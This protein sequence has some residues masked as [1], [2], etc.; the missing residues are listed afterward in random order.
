MTLKRKVNAGISGQ[1]TIPDTLHLYQA[2]RGTID[3]ISGGIYY[4]WRNETT[5][6]LEVSAVNSYSYR[7]YKNRKVCSS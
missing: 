1:R 3:N 4:L 2:S 6:C 5:D 7:D